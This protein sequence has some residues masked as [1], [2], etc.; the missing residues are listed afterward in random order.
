MCYNGK[1]SNVEN[2]LYKDPCIEYTE[3]DS[4]FW[5]DGFNLFSFENP[6]PNLEILDPKAVINWHGAMINNRSQ[7]SLKYDKS[8]SINLCRS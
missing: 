5:V 6:C 3:M 1:L 8:R 7:C 4:D 2:V